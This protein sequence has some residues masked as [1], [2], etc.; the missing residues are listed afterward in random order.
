MV[1]AFNSAISAKVDGIAVCLVDLKAFNGPVQKA[2]DAD[3]VVGYN[4]DAPNAR[5]SYIGQ[6][7]FVSGQE[8][9]KRIVDLGRGRRRAVHRDPGSLNIQPRIDGA[10]DSIKKA[11]GGDHAPHHRDG[12]GAAE[13][14]VHRR[15]LLGGPQGHQG[16]VRGRRRQHPGRG[17][18]DQE[19]QPARPGREGRRLRPARADDE[20]AGRR[21]DRLH[22][23]PAALSPGVPSVLEL[24]LQGVRDADRHRRR[25]HRTEVPGQQD[26]R[27]TS[28]PSRA[29][30][31]TRSQPASP[32]RSR[33]G[34]DRQRGRRAGDPAIA[35]GRAARSGARLAN[36]RRAG[37][38]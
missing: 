11:G 24:F 1:N 30:R 9:G 5:L 7:L 33:A 27:P 18:G 8:M 29:T 3:P 25:Q 35:R 17:A 4:A 31:A 10:I 38:C 16:D 32:R 28:R 37:V 19:V 36:R 12:G 6:D 34:R 22:D 13:G 2:L 21:T 14:A 20:P 15:R 26:G 23:R